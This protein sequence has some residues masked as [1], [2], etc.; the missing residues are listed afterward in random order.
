MNRQPWDESKLFN[1]PF[2][3]IGHYEEKINAAFSVSLRVKNVSDVRNK[4]TGLPIEIE[5]AIILNRIDPDPIE[6]NW[7]P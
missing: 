1:K 4:F 5:L 6:L 7:K 3:F 2:P